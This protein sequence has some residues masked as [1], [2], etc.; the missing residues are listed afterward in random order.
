M[1]KIETHAN[2]AISW[3]DLAASDVDAAIDFYSGLF[4]WSTFNDGTTPYTIFLVG[5]RP[6]AGVMELG[7][8]MGEMPPVWSTYVSVENADA[9][10]EAVVAAGGL[11]FQPP[12]EIP[13]GGRIA[14]IGD[15]AG[16]ALCLFEGNN[17]NGMKLM[18]EPGAPCWFDCL[19][20]DAD[21]AKAFYEAVFGWTSETMDAGGMTYHLFLRDGQPTCGVM[22]MPPVMPAEVPSHWV[23][24]FSIADVDAAATYVQAN[25]G[26]ITQSAMDTPFGRSCGAMDPWGASFMMID[27]S[28][29][30]PE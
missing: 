3:V 19:S 10:I 12:F 24:D 30:T 23:V 18:D 7:Q 5:E 4:G 20:R 9:T 6:V 14:V 16:A 8:E 1:V 26:R 15:P 22:A 21:A 11:V 13:N 29:A 25:G 27:R 28:S 2:H 17:D